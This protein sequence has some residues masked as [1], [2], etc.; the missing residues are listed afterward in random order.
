M[1]TQPQ[2]LAGY[3]VTETLSRFPSAPGYLACPRAGRGDMLYP[4]AG[5]GHQVRGWRAEPE[6]LAVEGQLSLQRAGDHVGAAEDVGFPG[7]GQAC[8]RHVAVVEDVAQVH[9][10]S[11]RDDVVVKPVEHQHGTADA[12]QP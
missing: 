12:L 2:R 9:G 8:V 10:L 4:A 1:R 7:E 5:A 11:R 3:T 6:H